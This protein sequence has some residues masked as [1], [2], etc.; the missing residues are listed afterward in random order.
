[1]P[2]IHW[3]VGACIPSNLS[4]SA[5]L[6]LGTRDRSGDSS[7]SRDWTQHHRAVLRLLHNPLKQ[8]LPH[9]PWIFII[10]QSPNLKVQRREFTSGS[11]HCVLG[12]LWYTE[13]SFEVWKW[14]SFPRVRFL[15][16]ECC[17]YA[18]CY[19]SSRSQGRFFLTVCLEKS[20]EIAPTKLTYFGSNST[21]NELLVARHSSFAMF[22][23]TPVALIFW[24]IIS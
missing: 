23:F 16:G 22:A 9:H 13:P 7:A 12:L 6:C 20:F 2:A 5:G 10:T 17:F 21:S 3:R 24:L 18:F 11:E 8:R 4:L 1:M 19:F 15:F 14:A